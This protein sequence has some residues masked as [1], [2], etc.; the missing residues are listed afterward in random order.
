[1]YRPLSNDNKGDKSEDQ[2][3]LSSLAHLMDDPWASASFFVAASNE[4]E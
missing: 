1:M 3:L 2:E 4:V